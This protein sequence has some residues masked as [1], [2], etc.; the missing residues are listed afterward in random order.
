MSL[1]KTEG[2]GTIEEI[3]EAM[4]WGS[5]KNVYVEPIIWT[6]EHVQRVKYKYAQTTSN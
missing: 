2:E 5:D 1:P 3:K 4:L 6:V